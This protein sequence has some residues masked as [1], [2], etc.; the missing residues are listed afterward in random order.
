MIFC[1]SFPSEWKLQI[2][3]DLQK[4]WVQA[5]EYVPVWIAP[6][7]LT[8]AGLFS[9]FVACIP[10]VVFCPTFQERVSFCSTISH[11]Q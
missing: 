11:V 2:I 6:N 5:V 1:T 4:F 7:V 3:V 10:L 9:N 8:L